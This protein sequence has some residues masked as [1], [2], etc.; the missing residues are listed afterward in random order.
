MP[1]GPGIPRGPPAP[2]SPT[3]ARRGGHPAPGQA[4]EVSRTLTNGSLDLAQNLVV[5][6]GPATLVVRNDLR[7]LVDFLGRTCVC[8]SAP[9]VV[10][11]GHSQGRAL[12]SAWPHAGPGPEQTQLGKSQLTR[13]A[14]QRSQGSQGRSELKPQATGRAGPAPRLPGHGLEEGPRAHR[15][16]VPLRQ[17]LAL[18]A[19]LEQATLFMP[20]E[21]RKRLLVVRLSL[22]R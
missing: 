20:V 21:E 2:S 22:S 4:A 13:T 18:P 15:G 5:G 12:G 9:G 3:T 19:L 8:P 11:D 6:N 10:G 16:Q 17:P 14:P 1:G 7:L